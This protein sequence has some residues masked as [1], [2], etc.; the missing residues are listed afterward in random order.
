MEDRILAGQALLSALSN[1]S[2]GARPL[3]MDFPRT[4]GNDLAHA[5]NHGLPAPPLAELDGQRPLK[6][7]P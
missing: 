3:R 1:G 7:Q 5:A 2:Q 4:N 6:E